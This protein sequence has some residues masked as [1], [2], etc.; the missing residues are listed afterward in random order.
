MKHGCIWEQAAPVW[1]VMQDIPFPCEF[2]PKVQ[3]SSKSDQ[4]L[5][6][7]D[8]NF[9]F[10]QVKFN[11][12]TWLVNNAQEEL[13]A[14]YQTLILTSW[15]KDDY[16][17][18]RTPADEFE[19]LE[20]LEDTVDIYY[21]HDRWTYEDDMGSREILKEIERSVAGQIK[22]KRMVDDA[23]LNIKLY[24]LITGWERWHY[25]H[26]RRLFEVFDTGACGFDATGYNSK[27]RLVEDLERLV[28]TLGPNRIYLNGCYS[29]NRLYDVPR[30]VMAFS[31]KVD[32]LEEAKD[33][34]G[35]YRKDLLYESVDK[36]ID[37]LHNVQ[38]GL[39][40]F[41][42]TEATGD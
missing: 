11:R 23:E 30:E 32:L 7:H 13:L 35:T 24:P 36:R 40:E 26:N 34:T 25:E 18:G 2:V 42:A 14:P 10:L 27:P 37:A 31:G 29:A 22:L 17:L 39:N 15:E 33:P 9:P 8:E 19:R 16:L 41:T 12:S 20:Q 1:S 4:Q 6:G 38:T 5:F 3:P 21:A 28:E